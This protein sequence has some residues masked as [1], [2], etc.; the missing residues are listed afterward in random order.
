MKRIVI[1]LTVIMCMVYSCQSDTTNQSKDVD[2]ENTEKKQPE[3]NLFDH[4]YVIAENKFLTEDCQLNI[5][6]DCAAVFWS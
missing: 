3:L 4:V 1:T 6:C 5:G 2:K